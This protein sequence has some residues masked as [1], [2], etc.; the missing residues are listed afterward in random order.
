MRIRWIE[1]LYGLSGGAAMR[2]ILP[3]LLLLGAPGCGGR[4]ARLP[5]VNLVIITIDTLRFDHLGCYGH[6]SIRTPMIDEW[7][8]EGVLFRDAIASVPLTLPSHT[9][10]LTGQFPP[11]N[12]V[13]DNGAYTLA[14]EKTTIAE[15]LKQAGYQT[16]AIL[17]AFPLNRKYGLNQGF[18]TYRDDIPREYVLYDERLA[19]GPKAYN[20]QFESEQ[21]RAEQVTPL[22]REWIDSLTDDPF[23]LWLHYFDPHGVYDPPPPYSNM[24]S[25]VSYPSDLYDAEITYLDHHLRDVKRLLEER[26]VYDNTIILFT[27]DH[28]E[29]LG[30][31]FERYHDQFIY[32]ATVQIPFVL[33]GG[34]VPDAWPGIVTAPVRSAD[35]LP[36]FLELAGVSH[37][38]DIDGVSLV[39][40]L[41]G[42]EPFPADLTQYVESY[43]P[44]HNLCV[45]LFGLR[46]NG[47]KYIEAPTPELYNLTDD[48]GETTNLADRHIA[49][50]AELRQELLQM[51]DSAEDIPEEVDFE[52]RKKL[53]ALGYI[54]RTERRI[55]MAENREAD[56]KDMARSIDGL[57]ESMEYFTYGMLDS[58]LAVSVRLME[59]FPGQPRI[60]DNVGNLQIR[61][62]YY[63]DAIRTFTG[64]TVSHPRYIKGYFWAGMA[65]LRMEQF[66]KAAEYLGKASAMDPTLDIARYNLGV[67][68][69]RSGDYSGAVREWNELIQ[70]GTDDRSIQLAKRSMLDVK[71]A[72]EEAQKTGRPIQIETN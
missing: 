56:P 60:Y 5:G 59:I 28:G 15:Y 55:T 70:S 45:R 41:D 11:S 50:A 22:V 9:T 25:D 20:L 8:R 51:I 12:G 24:Y 71:K 40:F 37:A 7:A 61:L 4:D 2:A 72:L 39:P 30:Q 13:H 47:W 6:E 38:D 53:E 10:F 43:S 3:L 17:S 46:R 36:T 1:R 54:Q 35:V 48:P 58:S 21:R 29:G 57:H 18:D 33:S 49:K 69:A 26:G 68:L 19:E 32:D 52:S 42:V 27:A 64:V 67:A 31:H 63:E 65:Y 16:G 34:A 66:T 62:G 44:Q 14:D 23:F